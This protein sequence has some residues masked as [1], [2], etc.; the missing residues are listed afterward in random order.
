MDIWSLFWDAKSVEEGVKHL[1]PS[2]VAGLILSDSTTHIEIVE[3]IPDKQEIDLK[4]SGITHSGERVTF[5][6][7]FTDPKSSLGRSERKKLR[8][9]L[10]TVTRNRRTVLGMSAPTFEKKTLL[11]RAEAILGS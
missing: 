2:S 3:A 8:V 6:Y 11:S 9:L 1:A 7:T 4:V 10:R 5:Y